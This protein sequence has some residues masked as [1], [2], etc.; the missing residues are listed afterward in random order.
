MK[1]SRFS[2]A[3]FYKWC[4]KYGGMDVD[5]SEAKWLNSLF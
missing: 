3:I 5:V 2:V 1:R 4:S